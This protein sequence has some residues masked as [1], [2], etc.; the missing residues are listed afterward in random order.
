M[1]IAHTSTE[2]RSLLRP[3]SCADLKQYLLAQSALITGLNYTVTFH[4][5]KVAQRIANVTLLQFSGIERYALT[6]EQLDTVL[7]SF[8]AAWSP[9][10]RGGMLSA[11]TTGALNR[12]GAAPVA[13]TLI[14]HWCK[15]AGDVLD[16]LVDAGVAHN[17]GTVYTKA[18][19][20]H[21][22]RSNVFLVIATDNIN[23]LTGGIVTYRVDGLFNTLNIL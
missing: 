6:V 20:K 13:D 2:T 5:S 8:E 21:L 15:Q 9:D 18:T 1:H 11:P 7:G 14:R 17:Y 4:N 19:P 22:Y 12:I 23:A 10:Q 3:S 16:Q